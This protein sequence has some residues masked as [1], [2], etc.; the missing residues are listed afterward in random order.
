MEEGGSSYLC[1]SSPPIAFCDVFALL[2]FER[3]NRNANCL[4]FY[5]IISMSLRFR[6]PIKVGLSTE[7][8]HILLNF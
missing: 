1:V 8:I 3:R 7:T 5:R 2:Y 4:A 6:H